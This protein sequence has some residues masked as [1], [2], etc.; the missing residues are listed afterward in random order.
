[1]YSVLEGKKMEEFKD[2]FIAFV[3]ILGFEK[4]VE[5]ADSGTGKSLSDL[6]KLTRKLGT[7]EDQKKFETRGAIVC[8]ESAC[9]QRDLDFQI[10]QI[11]DCVVV[12]SEISPAGAINLIDHCWQAVMELLDAG[13][14]CRGYINRG[15][16]YHEAGQFIGVGYQNAYHQEKTVTAFKRS[17]DERGTPFVEVA[18]VVCDYVNGCGDECVKESFSRYVKTDA[19]VTALFPFQRLQHSFAIGGRDDEFDPAEHRASNQNMRTYI[20]DL[21]QR[22]N[23]FVNKSDPKAV[24][25][26]A[27]YIEA[28]NEQLQRCNWIDN[29]INMLNTPSLRRTP[30][31]EQDDR[32]AIEGIKKI[33]D[34]PHWPPTVWRTAKYEALPQATALGCR[35]ED[36]IM[37]MITSNYVTLEIKYNNKIYAAHLVV[38][39]Q[40]KDRVGST[41]IFSSKDLT[42]AE[43]GE[44]ELM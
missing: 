43:L 21:S 26:A 40:L 22:I 35:V 30:R 38:P 13:I 8:P 41:L 42:V 1:M 24:R 32:T 2:K 25:K 23:S 34:L 37:P 15:R 19:G 9:L 17:A 28:L 18:P 6:L 27:H 33:R 16:I 5:A 4:L 10:T 14:M 12:S 3:D 36:V 44:V 20:N 31:I 39:K 7:P 29:L 11:T